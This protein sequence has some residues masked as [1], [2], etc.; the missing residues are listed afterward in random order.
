MNENLD[1]FLADFGLDVVFGDT[2]TKGILDMP[3]QNILSGNVLSTEYSLTFKTSSLPSLLS[4]D[5][6]SVDEISY[7]IREVEKIVDGNF[8][9]A[10]L[11]RV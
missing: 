6:L 4:G 10:L 9:R 2:Y 5:V 7:K 8:S 1:V 11:T 3:D